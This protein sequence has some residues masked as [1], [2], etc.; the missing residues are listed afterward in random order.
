[1]SV[2]KHQASSFVSIGF[3]KRSLTVFKYLLS[4]STM[5]VNRRVIVTD[6]F[7]KSWW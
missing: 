2:K 1:M 6:M 3:L 4:V 7:C 5:E